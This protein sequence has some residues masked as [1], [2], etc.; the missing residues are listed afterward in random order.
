MCGACDQIVNECRTHMRNFTVGGSIKNQQ[1][2]VFVKI[3]TGEI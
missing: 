3:I 2:S 1:K